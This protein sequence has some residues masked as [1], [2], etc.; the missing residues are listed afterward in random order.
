VVAAPRVVGRKLVELH[1]AALD[2]SRQQALYVI[3]VTLIQ[4]VDA[5]RF[6]A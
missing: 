5:H 1:A 3:L 2:L 4:H 6:T